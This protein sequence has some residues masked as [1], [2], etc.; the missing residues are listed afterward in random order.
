LR[1]WRAA[2]LVVVV[3]GASCNGALRFDETAGDGAVD[4]CGGAASGGWRTTECDPGSDDS[5]RLECEEGVTCT[6]ACG[7]SCSAS[8]E[9]DS[10][11]VVTAGSSASVAC[12]AGASCMFIL[13][14]SGSAT[15]ASGASC[16][17]QC[18]AE[19]SLSCQPG[20]VCE[21]RC[22][23]ADPRAVTGSAECPD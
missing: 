3:A 19:C 13:G 4:G 21:L 11:C 7:S 18:L 12:A 1:A 9:E 2:A 6:G 22:G 17:L 10:R 23:G 20:A 14:T 5:C 8:C 16:N 15:C